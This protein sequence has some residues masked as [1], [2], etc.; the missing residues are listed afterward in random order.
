MDRVIDSRDVIA[1]IED[2]RHCCADA[3]EAL[4]FKALLELAGEAEGYAADW[5]YGEALIRDTHFEEYAQ[6]LA[7]D[8]GAVNTESGWPN[9]CIDWK[10]AADQLRI[11]YTS[12]DFDGV[13]YWVR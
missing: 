12:V 7:E 5:Q 6:E 1:A 4:E 9:N 13:E 11:D 3:D 2:M 10:E 8:I